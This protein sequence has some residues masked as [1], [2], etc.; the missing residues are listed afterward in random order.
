MPD[1]LGLPLEILYLILDD[2]E[3]ASDVN[4]VA[5]TCRRLYQVAN[6]PY[7][8]PK[9][10][11][12]CSPMGLERIANN[13]NVDAI[14]KFLS[15]GVDFD[16]LYRAI[17]SPPDGLTSILLNLCGPEYF[18]K[19]IS[20]RDLAEIAIRRGHLDLLRLFISDNSLDT[21]I[22]EPIL[23][24]TRDGPLESVKLLIEAGFK[25][26]RTDGYYFP[27][28]AAADK[29]SLDKV[30][31]LLDAGADPNLEAFRPPRPHEPVYKPLQRAAI[32][33]HRDVVQYLLEKGAFY[34]H[35]EKFD[36]EG[37]EKLVGE[38]KEAIATLLLESIDLDEE[39]KDAETR[40]YLMAYAT[41]VGNES[42]VRRLLMFKTVIKRL[43]LEKAAYHGHTI[44]VKI[45]LDEVKSSRSAP[46]QK[47]NSIV[48]AIDGAIRGNHAS[49]LQEA[50]AYCSERVIN[51][52]GREILQHTV[53]NGNSEIWQVL[54]DHKVLDIVLNARGDRK[55]GLEALRDLLSIALESGNSTVLSHMLE[56]ADLRAF[57]FL[58][59]ET[60]EKL[61]MTAARCGQVDAIRQILT[62][63]VSLNPE[64]EMYKHIL[65]QAVEYRQAGIIK[66][67]L[68]N[69]F[70]ANGMYPTKN[71]GQDPLLC[72]LARWSPA[73][74][75]LTGRTAKTSDLMLSARLLLNNGAEVD[76]TGDSERTALEVAVRRHQF[77]LANELLQRGA[78]PLRENRFQSSAVQMILKTPSPSPDQLTLLLKNLSIHKPHHRDFIHQIPT[79]TSKWCVIPHAD[80]TLD[81]QRWTEIWDEIGC[82][83]KKKIS[84]NL[85]E[86]DE[87][88]RFI[89]EAPKD[90]DWWQRFIIIKE[91]R[92]FYWRTTSPAPIDRI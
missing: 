57:N 47:S 10:A 17:R 62:R 87:K 84:V 56:Q 6:N 1:I 9:F 55:I 21:H 66:L 42:L 2:L 82:I 29:G 39:L 7:L 11:Q 24:A 63:G 75:A 77:D 49:T 35:H 32:R 72:L 79:L 59:K 18:S 69:G 71:H 3:Y 36:A 64:D 45:L 76:A 13:N 34:T 90:S 12:A 53:E 20:K 46:E 60:S 4:A 61:L 73:G 65:V 91:L 51:R 37:I 31:L 50:L 68:D 44:I 19:T 41:A 38:S 74:R 80:P 5:Q 28:L 30:R 33:G 8:Y 89:M 22:H 43:A 78:D 67:F 70:D 25:V 58:D 52:R 14:R 88:Q 16:Q 23:N 27:L 85:A 83:K 15:S 40:A 26:N 81:M 54:L 92:K 48:Y 86:D